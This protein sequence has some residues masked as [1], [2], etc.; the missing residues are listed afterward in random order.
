MR[1]IQPTRPARS[2]CGLFHRQH[3][4]PFPR[5]GQHLNPPPAR[6]PPPLAMLEPRFWCL[7]PDARMSRTSYAT[8]AERDAADAAK[9]GS[10]GAPAPAAKTA[11]TAPTASGGGKSEASGANIPAGEKATAA[12]GELNLAYT[13]FSHPASPTIEAWEPHCAK[14]APRAKI[15]KNLFLKDKKKKTFVLVSAL[16]DTATRNLK[17]IEEHLKVKNL[18]LADPALLME[19]L[20]LKS[21]AVTPLSCLV[22]EKKEITFVLDKDMI[23][24]GKTAPLIFHPLSGNDASLTLG[25]DALL[26]YFKCV[27]AASCWKPGGGG[28]RARACVCLAAPHPRPGAHE[29]DGC[30]APAHTPPNTCAALCHAV[31]PKEA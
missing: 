31:C 23:E 19:K 25:T 12:L 4:E 20:G 11:P 27:A 29:Q 7:H 28:A 18:R 14:Y 16:A 3:L 21:G 24:A 6:L 2:L 9:G 26:A 5:L 15:C 8:A 13:A 10:G 17:P 30:R 22:D 1:L